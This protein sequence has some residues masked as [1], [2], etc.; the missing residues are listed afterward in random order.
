MEIMMASNTYV[1]GYHVEEL[2]YYYSE[3]HSLLG[4]EGIQG[5]STQNIGAMG[6]NLTIAILSMNRAS[7][8]IR[9]MNSIKKYIPEFAG[10]FLIG[11][12]GS[13]EVE[14]EKLYKKMREMPYRCR[15]IEFG[16]NFGVSGGRNRLFKEVQ[17]DWILSMDNDLYFV[18]NPLKKLQKDI[19]I[20]GCH[21][22]AL[23]LVDKSNHEMRMF[24]GHLYLENLV[25]KV[26]IGG[27]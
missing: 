27:S 11:D 19:A 23:P 2:R 13:D 7:L 9:L 25:N 5:V 21:F 26:G 15:M 3:E 4:S 1:K 17:T 8:T 12:N 22:M 14:R 16:K 20:L 24:H 18:G 6:Q 10:E